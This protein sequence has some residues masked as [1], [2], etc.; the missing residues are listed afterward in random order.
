MYNE[1]MHNMIQNGQFG[2][3]GP[4]YNPYMNQPNNMI[5]F[6]AMSQQIQNP[7]AYQPQNTTGY[8]FQPVGGYMTAPQQNMYGNPYYN[9]QYGYPQYGY[10]QPPYGNPYGYQQQYNYY[11]PY[12]SSGYTNYR[13]F[14]S[15]LAQQQYQN[16]QTEML[17]TKFRM[18]SKF[19]GT[20]LDEEELD[21]KLNPYNPANQ[22]TPEEIK[23]A[24]EIKFMNYCHELSMRPQVESQ[25][26]ANAR[27][28]REMSYN[29]HKELDSH[30]LC[31]FLEND[32]WKL[33]REEWI[34]Q[35]INKNANR[36]LSSMYDS[37]N[38]NELL[39]LHRSSNPYVN[40]LL[41]NSR[42]DNN[43]DDYEMGI[44]LA[45]DKERRRKQ[46]LEGK[47]PEYISSEETQ[48]R[49][50]EWTSEIMQQ[51]YNKGGRVN[52]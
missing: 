34:R 33:Q 46:I 16:V 4:S 48:K 38:Y 1:Q 11:D 47:I 5:S 2:T 27:I 14:I 43:L 10:Q 19:L 23:E 21:K 49:R 41:D 25:A 7:Y 35:N 6:G 15:P 36:N 26:E 13:P 20:P 32:L 18:V 42:Y 44:N 37:T 9:N 12:G 50:N 3:S 8:V 24:E 31:E 28:L 22:K 29:M 30:S 39:N 51:I 17:K 52:V 40:E 45:M